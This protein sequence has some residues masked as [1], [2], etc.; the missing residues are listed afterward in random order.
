LSPYPFHH[1]KYCNF[2]PLILLLI[3]S[4][5]SY[6]LSSYGADHLHTTTFV[7]TFLVLQKTAIFLFLL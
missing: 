1:T 3:I 7:Q 2:L 6:F 4:L 5:T